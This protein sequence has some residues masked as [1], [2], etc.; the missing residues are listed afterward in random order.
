MSD[1]TYKFYE[2]KFNNT[3]PIRGR[4]E[5][6]RPIGQRRRDWEKITR[7]DLGQGWY[8]YCAKLYDTEVVEYHP[9]GDV[10]LRIGG[11]A[12]PTTAEFIHAQ[13]PFACFK[14]NGK[15]WVRHRTNGDVKVYPLTNEPMRFRWLGA[16]EYEPAEPVMIKK[17]V[18]NRAKAKAAREPMVP[19][20]NWAKAFVSMTDGWLMHETRKQVFGWD[21]TEKRFKQAAIHGTDKQAYEKLLEAFNTEAPEEVYLDLFCRW[22]NLCDTEKRLAEHYTKEVDWNGRKFNTSANFYDIQVDFDKLKRKVYT[23]AE[24]FGSVHDTI[25]VEPTN[26]TMVNVV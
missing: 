18:V 21:D 3:K 12:T 9:N 16:H 2:N 26:R 23:W 20:L 24:K 22:A 7:K 19:F 25:E 11:W 13:S 10:V 17:H 14:K 4:T 15:L 5:E 1:T 8:A 6:I